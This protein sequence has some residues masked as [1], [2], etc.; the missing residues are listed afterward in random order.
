MAS[1]VI[2]RGMVIYA[3]AVNIGSAGLFA[4]DKHQAIQQAHRVPERRLCQTALMGGWA[5]GLLAMQLF[6]H[7]TKKKSFQRKYVEAI[8][9]NMVAVLPLGI[10]LWTSHPLR[11]AFTRDMTRFFLRRQPPNIGGNRKPPRMRR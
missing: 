5:G 7:K 9:T 3:G 2:A 6:R 11:S 1:A 8:M 10:A 4:Y